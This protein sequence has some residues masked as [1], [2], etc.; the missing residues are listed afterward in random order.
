MKVFEIRDEQDRLIEKLNYEFSQG[1]VN[2]LEFADKASDEL[3]N[4]YKIRYDQAMF[5]VMLAINRYTNS[6]AP[7][8]F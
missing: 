3:V 6:P 8:D 1:D 5:L 4:K 2:Y 7:L